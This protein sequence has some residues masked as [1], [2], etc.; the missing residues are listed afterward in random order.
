MKRL[1]LTRRA[2]TLALGS[3]LLAGCSVIPR[4]PVSS[5]VPDDRR[6]G[7]V[8][9]SSIPI[10]ADRHRIAL[11]VPTSGENGA[12]GQAIANATT[13]ALLDTG[14]N[15]LRI[16]T[17]D[18]SGNAQAAARRAVED[19]NT[20]ILG[21]L[22]GRNVPGVQAAARTANV[23]IV[24]FSN[25]ASYASPDVFVLGHVPE[26]GIARS[27]RYA[28]ENGDNAFA[29]LVPEGE[30]GRRA[31]AAM[32]ATVPG[33]GGVVT[34]SETYARGNTSIGSAARRLASRGLYDAVLIA[35]GPRLAGQGAAAIRANG[36]RPQI[37]GTEL[38]SGE[39][40]VLRVP[41]LRGAIFSAVSDSRYRQFVDSYEARFG[42][43]PY[44]VAT[45][46]YD[47]VLL[48]LR[49]ARDW[50]PGRDFPLRAMRS[51]GGFL[52]LDG[53]FRFG[54]DNVAQRAPEVRRIEDGRVAI[55]DPAPSGF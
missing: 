27:V 33:F 28:Q 42:N 9:S 53:A 16:T 21:P 11:L 20:L 46:G 37:I 52:G 19:G 30:Y 51:D 15:A 44:R 22:L 8:D 1:S 4:G 25:D 3:A 55:V 14:S 40:A 38:W 29:V 32:R 5:P 47:A 12:V 10:E 45:L 34:A 13:M 24:T 41:S 31:E 26:Q 2:A 35:D 39:S 17:Y 7:G 49:I 18:T 43:Q 36:D 50:E 6:T 23:P 54:P 48:T